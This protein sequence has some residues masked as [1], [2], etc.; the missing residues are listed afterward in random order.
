M[1]PRGTIVPVSLAKK[2]QLRP[3]QSLAVLQA[4]PGLRLDRDDLV[5]APFR[6]TS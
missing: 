6:P 3:G 2:L 1:P 5:D 4:P